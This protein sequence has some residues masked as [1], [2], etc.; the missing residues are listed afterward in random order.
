[1]IESLFVLQNTGKTYYFHAKTGETS[2]SLPAQLIKAA[3]E[4]ASEA[5][6]EQQEPTVQLPWRK[7]QDASGKTYYHNVETNETSWTVPI[8]A[9][10]E[11]ASVDDQSDASENVADIE[12]AVADDTQVKSVDQDTKDSLD[13]IDSVEDGAPSESPESVA[14]ESE[15][16]AIVDDATVQ[17]DHQNESLPSDNVANDSANDEPQNPSIFNRSVTQDQPEAEAIQSAD[18][19]PV[20]VVE[21]SVEVHSSK[22]AVVVDEDSCVVESDLPVVDAQLDVEPNQTAASDVDSTETTA[23][24]LPESVEGIAAVEKQCMDESNVPEE[25][26]QDSQPESS[27]S[28]CHLAEQS[29][30]LTEADAEPEIAD[31]VEALDSQPESSL[32]VSHLAE[33]SEVPAEITGESE[34]NDSVETGAESEIAVAGVESKVIAVETSEPVAAEPIVDDSTADQPQVELDSSKVFEIDASSDIKMMDAQADVSAEEQPVDSDADAAAVLDPAEVDPEETL[35]S[36]ELALDPAVKSVGPEENEEE[37]EHVGEGETASTEEPSNEDSEVVEVDSVA[38]K[39][40]DQSPVASDS[41]LPGNESEIVPSEEAPAAATETDLNSSSSALELQL[42]NQK[43]VQSTADVAS[44]EEQQDLQQSVPEASVVDVPAE[45][46][47]V[48]ESSKIDSV[49]SKADAVETEEVVSPA[50]V[51]SVNFVK[52]AARLSIRDLRPVEPESLLS[53]DVIPSVQPVVQRSFSAPVADKPTFC[54]WKKTVDK[55]NSPFLICVC[56]EW[57]F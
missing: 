10:S 16:K 45:P 3:A 19:E 52:P 18:S 24:S 5:S 21:S 8:V 48:S 12:P 33:Q 57:W 40:E 6:T 51:V 47:P 46:E 7:I 38:V 35:A 13:Q 28:V 11:T 39:L 23:E 14:V 34:I 22:D 17:S 44:L 53:M 25:V 50:N 2:W 29:E 30:A 43:S 31:L 15:C 20:S 4:V 56:F 32:S 26:A 54:P 1:L 41:E 49:Q 37:A 9:K 27:P 36:T 55:V 42:E